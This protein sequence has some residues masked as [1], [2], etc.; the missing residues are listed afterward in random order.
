MFKKSI[1]II[2]EI[3]AII[4]VSVFCYAVFVE[5]ESDIPVQP[6]V[7]DDAVDNKINEDDIT[8]DWQ[9]YRN[10][11]FGYEIK[12][13]SDWICDDKSLSLLMFYDPVAQNQ[14]RINGGSLIQGAK[15]EI[16]SEKRNS[17]L[18]LK[19]YVNT[20]HSENVQILEEKEITINN[21]KAIQRKGKHWT[22]TMATY[23][24]KDSIFYMIVIYIPQESSETKYI[25]SYN[26]ILST[27]KFIK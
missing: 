1:I 12:Y 24:Q 20:H 3:C 6:V 15:M 17:Q 7:N 26:Q 14:K 8:K 2:L 22:T 9:V 11:E 5:Q 19:D 23:F 18:S 21:I 10:E 4:V 13:P 16:Y 27:F 25:E